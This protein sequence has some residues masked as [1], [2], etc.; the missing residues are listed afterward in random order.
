MIYLCDIDGT[1]ADCSH[2]LHFIQ[3]K[4]KNWPAFYA[5]CKD[6]AP[7]PSVIEVINA[8]GRH[9]SIMFS[10]GRSEECKAATKTWLTSVVKFP[11]WHNLYMRKQGDYREDFIV[12]A[13]LLE[14]IKKDH[15]YR[16]IGGAFE[17]RQQVV[18]MYRAKGIKVF[19]VAKGD[20]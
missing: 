17:D 4:P 18:D 11:W 12:K 3:N 9:H 2:R 14:Q 16:E 7:I 19:Q 6:D 10:T 13:E 1:V 8:L 5:A 20:F 15:P